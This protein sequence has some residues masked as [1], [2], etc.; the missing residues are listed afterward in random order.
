VVA[1]PGAAVAVAAAAVMAPPAAVA[2]L[3]AVAAV[4]ALAAVAERGGRRAVACILLAVCPCPA[5]CRLP[6]A[7]AD[8]QHVNA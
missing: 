2:V 6:A 4:T 7:G 8:S 1:A 5:P 3:A